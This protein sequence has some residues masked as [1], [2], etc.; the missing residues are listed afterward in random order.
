MSALSNLATSTG[1]STTTL[2]SWYDAAQQNLINNAASAAGSAPQL[3]Q[4]VAQGAINTL[5]QP[6]NAFNQATNTLGSIASGA[7]NPWITDPTTGAVTPNT[8][9]A[10][11]GL[12]AAQRDQLNQMLPTLTS[13]TEAGAIGSGN[14]GSLR[15]QTAVDTAKANALAQLQAQQMQSALQNQA[16]GVN[17]GIGQSNAANQLLTDQMKVGQEQ[18]AAPFT[19]AANYGNILASINA[20]QTVK[21]EKTPDFYSQLGGLTSGLAGLGTSANNILTQLGIKGGLS[22]L[23]GSIGKLFDSSSGGGGGVSMDNVNSITTPGGITLQPRGDGTYTNP[24]GII[25]NSDNTP[26]NDVSLATNVNPYDASSYGD[27]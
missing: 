24:D 1:S 11:G 4:T 15:G 13:G 19:N 18:M 25:V 5:Q 14:F 8:N 10:M 20:P 21:T 16:T 7:A 22:G 12:F 2:P 17:A 26:I 23:A 6:N 3:N 27:G 9:T